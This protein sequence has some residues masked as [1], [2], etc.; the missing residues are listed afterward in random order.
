MSKVISLQSGKFDD[1]LRCLSLLKDV[2]NDVDIRGGFVRQRTNDKATAFEIDL[3]AILNDADIPLVGIKQKLDLLKCFQGNDVEIIV[4]K[5]HFVLHDQ[6]SSIKIIYPNL[7]FIDNKYMTKEERESI[8]NLDSENEILSVE[9]SKTVSDRMRSI[10][11][12]FNV[13]TVQVE[14]KGEKASICARTTPKDQHAKFVKD[15]VTERVLNC[16]SNLVVTPF[17]IDHDNDIQMKMYNPQE[18]VVDVEFRTS[19]SN[20]DVNLYGRSALID[21]E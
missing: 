4:E 18:T 20:I 16:T 21:I 6:Y 15:I 10:T 3:T 2:C 17:V 19:V 7:E 11:Q 9:I 8:F 1:L 14:F 5:D 13:R 12:G